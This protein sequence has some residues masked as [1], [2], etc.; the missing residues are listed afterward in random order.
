MGSLRYFHSGKDAPQGPE[1]HLIQSRQH[2]QVGERT[3]RLEMHHNRG[4]VR[5][6]K[7]H[8]LYILILAALC[9][10]GVLEEI[11][12]KRR[13]PRCLPMCVEILQQVDCFVARL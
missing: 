3:V 2:Q 8:H 7:D 11:I 5:I 4:L 12:H 13:Q 10:E 9:G 1:R 6:R